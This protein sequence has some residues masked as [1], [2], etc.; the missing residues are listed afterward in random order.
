[1]D[2]LSIAFAFVLGFLSLRVGLPPLVGY[3]AAGFL[4]HAAGFG[5]GEALHEIA[6]LGVLLLLFTIGLKLRLGSLARPE[7]WATASLH[8]TIMVV[9]LGA[10]VFVLGTAGLSA[11]AGLDIGRSAL[12][13]FA[14]SFSSTVF[15]VKV[16]E[17][18]GE[19]G[20]LH[21][22]G[23]IGIL[24]MQDLFAVIFL[25]ASMGKIPSLWALALLGLPLLRPLLLALLA[26]CGHG[27]LLLMGGLLITV[28]GSALF[29]LVGLKPDLGALVLGVLLS[30]HAKADELSKTLLRFK[31]LFLVGFFLQIGIT[32]V[33]TLEAV[34]IAL[35]FTALVPL[36]V[37]LFFFLLTRFRLRARTS[38]LT[39]LSLA[40]YSEFGLI[41]GAVGVANGW[42]S[43][44]WLLIVALSLAISL[45]AT[46]PLNAAS[47]ELYTRFAKRL[48][49]FET[50]KRIPGDEFI[51]PGDARIAV[52][53]MG[54][55]GT[56]VYDIMRE[57]FGDVVIG[58]DLDDRLVERHREAGRNVIVGDAVDEDYWE[59]NRGS[60]RTR[61]ETLFLTMSSQRENLSVARRIVREKGE[62]FVAATARFDDEIRQLE[63]AGV[64]A[65]FNLYTGA[66]LGFA[67]LVSKR[68]GE[69]GQRPA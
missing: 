17:E 29:E 19:M 18:K 10:L 24:I 58:I 52:M 49:R 66:G 32:Y 47:H 54:R 7:V 31:D 50:T 2:P 44:E 57:R 45:V 65:I 15:A 25:T 46:S 28:G 33:P 42:L 56:E 36:K 8:A 21:G 20:T 69:L 53:G 63:E 12:I 22:R 41:V 43:G 34:L 4:L 9:V 67:E 59:R 37:V 16:L 39:S 11:F 48:L 61:I 23:A 6:D 35:L 62:V 64:D 1:M 27:E 40:N 68:M 5:S 13:G 3:L 38:T 14:L 51:D 30:G 55:V 26:R 60:A